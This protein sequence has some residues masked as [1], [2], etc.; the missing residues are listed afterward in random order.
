MKG[1]IHRLVE[2]DKQTLGKFYLFNGVNEIF[3]CVVLELPDKDNQRNISNICS[4]VYT[5]KRRWSEKYGWHYHILDT[6]G[7]DL[8]LIHF[9][10]Y[11]KDTR[12]CILFGNKFAD[13]DNDGYRDITSSK[14]TMAK[15]LDVAPEEF[16]IMIDD[17]YLI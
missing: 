10:N 11:Y 5:A 15:L 17:F 1:V 16:T 13:I 2:E 8:I 3:S 12:G 9:G 7:R 14:K 6:E 4:G